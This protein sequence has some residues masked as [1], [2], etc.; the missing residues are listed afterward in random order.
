M[1]DIQVNGKKVLLR[2][3]FNVPLKKGQITD[4]S[5]LRGALPTIGCF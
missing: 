5:R 2:C 3:D 4:D 1:E